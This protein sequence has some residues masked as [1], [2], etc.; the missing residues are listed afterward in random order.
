VIPKMMAAVIVL[1][2]LVACSPKHQQTTDTSDYAAIAVNPAPPGAMLVTMTDCR[3]GWAWEELGA[4]TYQCA[5]GNPVVMVNEKQYDAAVGEVPKIS[6]SRE[7][8]SFPTPQ[9]YA[10]SDPP[11]WQWANLA[12]QRYCF[13]Y[14]PAPISWTS[15]LAMPDDVAQNVLFEHP[16]ARKHASLLGKPPTGYDTPYGDG[17]NWCNSKT[18]ECTAMACLTRRYAP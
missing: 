18:N 9:P 8:E 7:Y 11:E 4:Q 13:G 17:C 10:A 3:L 5:T 2:V 14:D 1:A 12:L 15:C 6:S 16:S